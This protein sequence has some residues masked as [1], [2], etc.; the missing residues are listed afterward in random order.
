MHRTLG[1]LVLSFGLAARLGAQ[2]LPPEMQRFAEDFVTERPIPAEL[3]TRLRSWITRT[4][5]VRIV[6][7]IYFVGTS[8]LAAYLITTREGHVLIDGAMPSSAMDIDASIRKAGFRPEDVRWQLIT[9]AHIDHAG[10]AAHFQKLGARVAVM[11][12]D[13][14][15]LK[16]GGKADFRYG[17]VPSFYFP[18]VTAD[19]TLKDGDVV[20]LGKV[21]MTARLG[22]GHTKGATTWTTT[23]E[24]GG[25]SYSVVFPCCMGI[26][27]GYRLLIRP[28]YPGIADDYRRTIA[29]LEA[30]K[31]DVWLPAHTD[32]FEF[33][34]KRTRAATEGAAAW[35]DPEG[36]RLWLARGKEN[37]EKL[38]TME[39]AAKRKPS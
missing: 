35:V 5:P 38:L 21:R 26:N 20:A 25:K 9:H 24:D 28:S 7:P 33:E 15:T 39:N 1:G 2:D 34:S 17:D 32:M 12:R 30:L 8:G 11:D 37:L 23:V 36:Y 4:D 16:T 19:R 22:A 18:A 3:T 10:T 13:F 27:S 6:G 29:M 14:E 31:P